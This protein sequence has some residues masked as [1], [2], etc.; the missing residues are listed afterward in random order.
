MLVETGKD[1]TM[2]T[3]YMEKEICHCAEM[4]WNT[5]LGLPLARKDIDQPIQEPENLRCAT[6]IKG[7]WNGWLVITLTP[8]LTSTASSIF[9]GESTPSMEEE[10]IED[11]LKELANQI[12]GNLKNLVP[13]PSSIEIPIMSFKA[14]DLQFPNTE[15]KTRLTF[16]CEG[17]LIE[18]QLL[19]LSD[20]NINN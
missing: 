12:G 2:S 17:D 14:T 8:R 16:E 4:V 7:R 3:Q 10:N 15:L 1:K 11:T 5:T 19:E 18:F 13:Q 6:K 9:F 20:E